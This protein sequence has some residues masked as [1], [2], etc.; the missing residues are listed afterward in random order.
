V[1]GPSHVIAPCHVVG[2]VIGPGDVVLAAPAHLFSGGGEN[3]KKVNKNVVRRE[4][5][6]ILY[7][8]TYI[9]YFSLLS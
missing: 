7:N 4:Q 8:Y 2:H 1:I 5:L 3:D 9:C 6:A